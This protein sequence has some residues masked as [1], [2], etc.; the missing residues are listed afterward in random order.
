M[1]AAQIRQSSQ[2][3]A[4]ERLAQESQVPLDD[5]RRLYASELAKL[6]VGARIRGFLPVL[7]LRK[8]RR[9]LRTGSA[10]QPLAADRRSPKRIRRS[11]SSHGASRRD[12][13]F[14]TRRV[15]R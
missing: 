6:E 12:A 7:A 13:R 1:C 2:G 11:P 14:L 4:L 3:L 8:V 5:V 15:P 9:T 10:K